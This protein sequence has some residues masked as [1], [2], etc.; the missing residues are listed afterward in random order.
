MPL[1]AGVPVGIEVSRPEAER[2]SADDQATR[3]EAD[4]L[5]DALL[6]A[7]RVAALRQGVPGVCGNC[8]LRCLPLAVYCDIDCRDDHQRRQAVL[9]R[10]GRAGGARGA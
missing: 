2:L 8:G 3:S 4:F 10:Q 7:R 9:A 1:R 6:Q 5:A